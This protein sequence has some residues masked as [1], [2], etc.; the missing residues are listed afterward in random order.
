MGLSMSIF[1]KTYDRSGNG[2]KI[3]YKKKQHNYY[4]NNP[5]WW[6]RIYT[7]KKRRMDDKKIILHAIR[8]SSFEC[9]VFLPQNKPDN[10]F[11]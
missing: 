4:W 10:Y 3:N 2:K 1:N 9:A 7:T 8:Y 5:S 6:D 11:W